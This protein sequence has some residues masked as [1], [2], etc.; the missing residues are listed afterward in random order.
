RFRRCG[1]PPH[2]GGGPRAGYVS[3][4]RGTHLRAFFHHQAAR[5]GHGACDLPQN[6]G[7]ARR[8]H[9]GR[10]G[11]ATGHSLP[12]HVAGAR[13][14]EDP[15]RETVF[16][17]D[18]DASIREGLAN[19]LEAVGIASEQFGSAEDFLG[20]WD[21][22]R[23]GCLVLDARL[24]GMTGVEFQERLRTSSISI[25]IIFMTAHGDIPMVRK[26]MK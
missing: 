6:R 13:M 15:A 22:T 16:V 2:Y 26:V 3:G 12:F 18:D 19:L 4:N 25:P 20:Q 5:H 1:P 8:P 17:V 14:S 21:P 23:P 10:A 11:R 7:V 9:L 24:P